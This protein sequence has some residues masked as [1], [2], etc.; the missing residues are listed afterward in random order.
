MIFLCEVRK[1][2]K[3]FSYYSIFHQ[4]VS[5]LSRI[6]FGNYNTKFLQHTNNNLLAFHAVIRIA[7]A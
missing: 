4:P 7:I 6:A 5:K 2:F 3:N 1:Y